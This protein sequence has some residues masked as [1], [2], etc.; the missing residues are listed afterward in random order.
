VR[1]YHDD[2]V[3]LAEV[4][5][6]LDQALRSGG[7]AVVIAN[8]HR[9]DTLKRRL[10]SLGSL[11]NSP[12]L[13]PGRLIAL[14]AQEALDHFMVDGWPDAQR[15]D[16]TVG[17]TVRDACAA[18]DTVHA[19]GEMVAL[20]CMQ[21]LYD[22]AIRLE[23][24]WN[25]LRE[26]CRFSLFCAYPWRLFPTEELASAFHDICTEHDH[27][28]AQEHPTPD[29]P[30]DVQLRLARLEQR[31]VAL[32][33][34]VV[35]LKESEQ[36]LKRRERELA[37]FMEGAV[38]GLH[39]VGPDGTILWANN[40]E[41]TMLGYRWEEYVGHHISEFHLDQDVI[42]DILT[43]LLD[44]ETLYDCPARLRCK[45]G[46]IKHVVI[47]SNGSF[48]D[49]SLRYTRCFT[50]D[51]T[52]RH[53]LELA[54]REREAL[55]A[56][57]TASNRAKDEFLAMLSHELRNPLAPIS[58]AAQVLMLAADDPER[59]RHTAGIVERQ[60]GHLSGLIDDLLD[61]ARVTRGVIVLER[62]RLDF[63][64]IVSDAIEQAKP[65]MEA[66]RHR[67]LVHVPPAAVPVLADRKRMLQVVANVL[68]NAG[69][70]TPE[71]GQIS[72]RLDAE[73]EHMTL[74]VSDNGIGM[75]PELVARVFDLFTQGE[76]G[77]DRSQG[78]LG[79]GLALVKNL[80]ELHGGNVHADSA[81][82]GKGSTFTIC[83]PLLSEESAPTSERAASSL[84]RL[85]KHSLRVM[86][87]D[88]NADAADT[89][90]MLLSM[91][92]HE[93][94]ACYT[95][96]DATE[97][98]RSTRTQV[99][100]LDIGLPDLDGFA[101]AKRLRA[102]PETAGATLIAATGYGHEQ[103]RQRALAAGFDHH[104]VKPVSIEALL[105]ILAALP[106]A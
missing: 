83:L 9:V 31:T 100:I 25:G 105:A 28:R 24:L 15:F 52:E 5:A 4:A 48:E 33:A 7:S 70:Y 44:G 40:A 16:A 76:R 37:D 34:E 43:R 41:L 6:F 36:A 54:Y 10:V 39:R 21:G 92:G 27:V 64:Q 19:F 91:A 1:F 86:V 72:V 89:L 75:T 104:L 20:L 85:D 94:Y 106:R 18:A 58:A 68:S 22:A 88:D 26:K 12:D 42:D 96:A 74:T 97:S 98:A 63:R 82:P 95:A 84:P 81:G 65:Q 8:P 2:E 53:Q 50:R 59:V 38:E 60:V 29:L 45:D 102:M 77:A 67:L 56:E 61:V 69:R 49:G 87:V 79:L 90:C 99:F 47:H 66:Y 80:V 35:R 11:K 55:L 46:S 93:A 57:L 17:K 71:G 13:P 23:Q 32:Q 30:L 62:H 78:G 103:D 14:D 3:L 73:K 51:A 101:L